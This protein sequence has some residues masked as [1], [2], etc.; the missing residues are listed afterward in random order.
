MVLRVGLKRVGLC[1][2]VDMGHTKSV[3]KQQNIHMHACT[4]AHTHACMH[5]RTHACTH[6]RT[7]LQ[8]PL[9]VITQ[10]SHL[11]VT[12]HVNNYITHS[13][14]SFHST[15]LLQARMQKLI[16]LPR[17]ISYGKSCLIT[18]VNNIVVQKVKSNSIGIHDINELLPK[19]IKDFCKMKYGIVYI[20]TG[21]PSNR[22]N[23]SYID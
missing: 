7:C 13:L 19:L 21:P 6:A 23:N 22:H 14:E 9:H 8:S 1:V 20:V 4:H 18:L 11:W 16:S 5:A 17:I 3:A 15:F 2:D 12:F 10:G